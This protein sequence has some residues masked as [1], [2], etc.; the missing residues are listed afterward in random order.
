MSFLKA[1]EVR[2]L[3][4]DCPCQCISSK[5]LS[6]SSASGV[7]WTYLNSQLKPPLLCQVENRVQL[8]VL[9][10]WKLVA[11]LLVIKDCTTTAFVRW[12]GRF[13]NAA[14]WVFLDL[15]GNLRVDLHLSLLRAFSGKWENRVSPNY[16]KVTFVQHFSSLFRQRP[17]P[18]N[19]GEPY[20]VSAV[21]WCYGPLDASSALDELTNHKERQ[22]C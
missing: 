5:Q 4:N 18:W 14:D 2:C 12:R 7:L 13:C 11:V 16:P 21:C 22:I 15:F 8:S 3:R 17:K 10:A 19:L 6:R 1:L 20:A 9:V